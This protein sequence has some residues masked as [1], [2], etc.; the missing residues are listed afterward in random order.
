ME[1][2]II[3][4]SGDL[5]NP[6]LSSLLT[7]PNVKTSPP[8][9]ISKLN[10][11]DLLAQD[12][13]ELLLGRSLSIGEAGCL[14]A[15]S[16]CW[17]TGTTEWMLVLED[18]VDL[19]LGSFESIRQFSENLQFNHPAVVHLFDGKAKNSASPKLR[20]LMFQPSGTVAYLINSAARELA[21]EKLIGTADW[22]FHFTG[23]VKFYS[24]WGL[25]I[26]EKGGTTSTIG[27]SRSKNKG[28]WGF[29]LRAV[30]RLPRIFSRFGMNGIMFSLVSPLLRD[31]TFRFRR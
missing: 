14:L 23:R 6:Q 20:S 24:Y 11:T 19:D 25:G 1:T 8:V 7:S 31:T 2:V 22:P 26:S 10:K 16:Y 18:D 21:P 15:H 28:S 12:L 4:I 29:Y 5:R 3:G 30:G 9:F 17:K 13:N 27:A